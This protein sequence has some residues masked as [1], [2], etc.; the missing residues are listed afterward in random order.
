MRAH[1]VQLVGLAHHVA[2][3]ARLNA[4]GC[5]VDGTAPVAPGRQQ[6]GKPW[7]PRL[8]PT[9]ACARRRAPAAATVCCIAATVCGVAAACCIAATCC[10]AAA[11]GPSSGLSASVWRHCRGRRRRF[12]AFGGPQ[13]R[14]KPSPD[15]LVGEQRGSTGTKH[16]YRAHCCRCYPPVPNY[17]SSPPISQAHRLARLSVY[18]S[19]WNSLLRSSPPLA[20]LSLTPPNRK[21]RAPLCT[22]QPNDARGPGAMPAR[23]TRS[24]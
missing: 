2:P 19:L 3:E 15:G 21:A 11:A 4:R 18:M 10:I 20:S 9:A 1:L 8:P 23:L 24:H 17:Y 14:S 6:R 5:L 12:A 16:T 22:A 7:V 13:L